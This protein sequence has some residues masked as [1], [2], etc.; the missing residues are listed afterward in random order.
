MYIDIA[1]SRY[2]LRVIVDSLFLF[3][4]Y[5]DYCIARM[6]FSRVIISRI[7]IF[8]VTFRVILSFFIIIRFI[9]LKNSSAAAIF[10]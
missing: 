1:I 7:I 9:I 2:R 6:L 3:R 10:F 5:D 8:R 4:C